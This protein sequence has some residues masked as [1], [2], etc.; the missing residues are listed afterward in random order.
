MNNNTYVNR[1]KAG[2]ASG[3]LEVSLRRLAEFMEKAQKIKGRVKSAMFY[4]V[5]VLIAGIAVASQCSAAGLAPGEYDPSFQPVFPETGSI[6]GAASGLA[7]SVW[8]VFTDKTNSIVRQLRSNGSIN[9]DVADVHVQGIV[10][11]VS[12]D[13]AGNVY[14]GGSFR[15]VDGIARIGLARLNAAGTLDANFPKAIPG[16]NNNSDPTI[17]RIALLANGQLIVIG[18]FSKFGGKPAPGCIKLGFDGAPVGGVAEQ[19]IAKGLRDPVG[20]LQALPDGRALIEGI[21]VAY[22]DGQNNVTIILTNGFTRDSYRSH[23]GFDGNGQIYANYLIFSTST[24]VANTLVRF[25]LDGKIDPSFEP[26]GLG[27][28]GG[29]GNSVYTE[30]FPQNGGSFLTIGSIVQSGATLPNTIM[31]LKDNSSID[32]TFVFRTPSGRTH[33]PNSSIYLFPGD[34]SWTFVRLDDADESGLLHQQLLRLYTPAGPAGLRFLGDPLGNQLIGIEGQALILS[35]PFGTVPNP[36]LQWTHAQTNVP[37]GTNFNLSLFPAMSDQGQYQLI[38]GSGGASVTSPPI[39]VHLDYAPTHAGSIDPSFDSQSKPGVR[40]VL[41]NPLGGYYF[42]GSFSNV[43]GHETR[44][45]ARTLPDGSIDRSFVGYR[46]YTNQMTVNSPESI[47]VLSNGMVLASHYRFKPSSIHQTPIPG[48]LLRL[49][50]DGSVDPNFNAN[51]SML[52]DPHGTTVQ[53]DGRI[54]VLNQGSTYNTDGAP[55]NRV[56]RLLSDGSLDPSFA[57]YAVGNSSVGGVGVL[58]DGRIL[59]TAYRLD[60]PSTLHPVLVWLS[61]TGTVEKQLDIPWGRV[62]LLSD[63]RIA[64]WSKNSTSSDPPIAILDSEGKLDPSF[65]VGSN[66]GIGIRD[67]TEYPGHRLLVILDLPGARQ[68]IDRLGMDGT[69]D[70]TFHFAPIFHRIPSIQS[71]A[72]DLQGDIVIGGSFEDNSPFQRQNLIRLHGVDELNIAVSRSLT[73]NVA[74]AHQSRAG[75][76]YLFQGCDG[77]DG[78]WANIGTSSGDNQWTPL[79]APAGNRGS[80]GF[81]RLRLL[82]E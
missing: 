29:W 1:V 41:A 46:G 40:A 42:T 74:Y 81:Y 70:P 18:T 35:T 78:D 76:R 36:T 24:V 54:L 23:F 53:P 32:S 57:A 4:P 82:N 48:V 77:L 28:F 10:Y 16:G 62:R 31:R 22:V 17:W 38:V 65:Q 37:S 44:R 80:V 30:I 61:E 68:I 14:I 60:P 39:A 34:S 56:V 75:H 69:R 2:E 6:V 27:S 45:I 9:P 71:V 63:E 55:L 51:V 58:K 3:A 7:D 47:T 49:T 8:V 33:L 79:N 72:V 20:R 21:Q 5:S 64:V 13:S 59:V 43:A 11:C 19:L 50:L 12:S 25:G 66:Y 52:D 73:G 26:I 15:R 67:V